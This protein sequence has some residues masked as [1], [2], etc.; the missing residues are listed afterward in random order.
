MNN[1]LIEQYQPVSDTMAR[2]CRHALQ[3]VI[4][5][6]IPKEICQRILLCLSEALT[7]LVVHAQAPSEIGFR[8]SQESD[9]WLLQI[10]DDG[11]AW[12]PTQHLD[13]DLLTGFSDIESGR[14]VALLHAQSDNITYIKAHATIKASPIIKAHPMA[15]TCK[16]YNQLQLFWSLPKIQSQQ[17]I[18]IVED[19][20]SLRLLFKT[21]LAKRYHIITA[22]NGYQA[23]E[24]LATTKID[25]VLSDIRMPEMN[26]L[27]LR[28]KINQQNGSE[29]IPFVFLTAQDD[30]MVQDQA[31]ELG[32]DDYLIKPI[33]KTQLI[34]IVQRIL[35]RSKQI[36][37]RLTTRIDKQITS[38]L[39]PNIP[40][41][42]NGWRLHLATRNTG[43]GGGDLLLHH[44]FDNKT[45]LLLTDIM[46]HDDSAKFF[47]HAYGGYLY[48]LLQ[49]MPSNYGP[50]YMLQQ[51][52]HCAMTDNLLSQVTLTC[53]SL[54]LS[55]QG[56]IN[57]ATAGHPAPLLISD[58]KI[59]PI[60]TSGILPGLIE[61]CDYKNE[62]L[63][64]KPGQ[65]IAVFTDGLF[66]SAKDNAARAHLE[67]QI[68]GALLTTLHL[69][70]T[71]A[72]D[73]VMSLFDA[74]TGQQPS[75]DTLLLLLEPVQF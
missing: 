53:C 18:L 46:G 39:Q 63:T 52:S 54:Q 61:H 68:N 66:E 37:Q 27:T 65:R 72:L 59:R 50:E 11:Q 23:L 26:G 64:I 49:S 12:D 29:I 56:K 34:K 45:Q 21:Y 25:L 19:N 24:K 6:Q 32:I 2:E 7:N 51:L 41:L 35:E 15:T 74:I 55:A 38:S 69:P 3:T 67:E 33:C 14:G 48:G 10:L 44:E 62:K 36:Y 31:F 70:I 16:K 75:D 57:I 42:A 20:A 73:N 13:D 28:K 71:Q 8:F 58:N 60:E 5:Q 47:S 43:Q 1:L 4:D 40:T 9:G 17:T 22:S 30:E